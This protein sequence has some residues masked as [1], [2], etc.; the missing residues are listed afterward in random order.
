MMD[1][2]L[3]DR[4]T[5]TSFVLLHDCLTKDRTT[6]VTDQSESIVLARLITSTD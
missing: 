6:A 3:R 4:A 1:S 2:A 5:A